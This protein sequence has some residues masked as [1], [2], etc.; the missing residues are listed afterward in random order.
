MSSKTNKMV[1]HVQNVT[2][3]LTSNKKNIPKEKRKGKKK[4]SR[5]RR[6]LFVTW[7]PATLEDVFEFKGD[8]TLTP[9]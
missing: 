9:M 3:T 2:S 5:K 8:R 1:S 7:G 6:G 4:R